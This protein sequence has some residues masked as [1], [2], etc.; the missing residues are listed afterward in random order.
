M[1]SLPMTL[2]FT[3][4]GAFLILIGFVFGQDEPQN[5]GLRWYQVLKTDIGARIVFW[6]AGLAALAHAGFVQFM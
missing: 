1:Q 2:L 6:I 4:L 5:E 3:A